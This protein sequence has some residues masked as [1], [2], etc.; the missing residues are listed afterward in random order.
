MRAKPVALNYVALFSVILASRLI[1]AKPTPSS[2][3]ANARFKTS[4]GTSVDQVASARSV[5]TACAKILANAVDNLWEGLES[6]PAKIQ[7]EVQKTSPNN[8]VDLGSLLE[9][10]WS[11]G[12]PVL[13]LPDLPIIGRKMEGMVTY[14]RSRPVVVLTKKVSQCDWMLYFWLTN[15]ATSL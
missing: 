15:S 5:A 12:I 13:F 3:T 1:E 4:S 9:F 8:W 14:A 10:S 7:K 11:A 6:D 2:Q